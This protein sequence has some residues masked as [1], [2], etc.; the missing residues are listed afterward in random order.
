M[1]PIAN[2]VMVCTFFKSLAMETNTSQQ[3]RLNCLKALAAGSGYGLNDCN[4]DQL[5]QGILN[6]TRL[7]SGY[8]MIQT[9]LDT[10]NMNVFPCRGNLK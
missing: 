4:Q 2:R 7:P 10:G 6:F 9:P 5:D 8:L 1:T 3:L